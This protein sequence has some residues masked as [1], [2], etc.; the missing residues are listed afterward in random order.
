MDL[1]DLS[2]RLDRQEGDIDRLRVRVGKL[3]SQVATIIYVGV[4]LLVIA[5]FSRW[6]S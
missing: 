1:D 5:A 2:D 3:E 4:V 6:A